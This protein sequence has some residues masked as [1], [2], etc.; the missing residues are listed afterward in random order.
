VSSSETTRLPRAAPPPGA[1]ATAA[2]TAAGTAAGAEAAL[3]PPR[4]PSTLSAVLAATLPVL[5]RAA[6][7][8]RQMPDRLQHPLRRRRAVRA[9]AHGF[10]PRSVLFVCHGNICR[11]P[12]AA[13][14]FRRALPEPLRTRIRVR[15][16]GFIGRGRPAPAEALRVARRKGIDLAAHRSELVAAALISSAD[17]I[18]VMDAQQRRA[19]HTRF[20]RRLDDIVVLGDFDPEPIETRA[21]LDPIERPESAYEASYRRIERCVR[22]LADAVAVRNGVLGA[23]IRSAR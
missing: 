21:I 19:V 6:R 16:A 15:S 13:A 22:V 17:L 5:R 12:F 18:V 10:V 1:P 11:S 9:V 4:P 23:A 8:L 3:R 2:A 7:T 20:G 14:A